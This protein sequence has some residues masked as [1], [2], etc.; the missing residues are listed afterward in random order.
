MWEVDPWVLDDGHPPRLPW[1]KLR[2]H[3]LRNNAVLR[4]NP[5]GLHWGSLGFL[6]MPMGAHN[7]VTLPVPPP[8]GLGEAERRRIGFSL[9]SDPGSIC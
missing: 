3:R 6:A 2:I 5:P 7:P 9:L 1:G 4:E 8:T